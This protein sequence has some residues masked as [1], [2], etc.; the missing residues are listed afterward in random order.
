MK[1][2]QSEKIKDILDDLYEIDP[3][4][5]HYEEEIKKTIKELLKSKPN[6]KI[7][8]KF[9]SELREK[10]I[11]R[12]EELQYEPQKKGFSFW[13]TFFGTKFSYAV[14]GA[15]V[16]VLFIG[17]FVYLAN[18]GNVPGLNRGMFPKMLEKTSLSN[19]A[20][21]SLKSE[22]QNV[23]TLE[24]RGGGGFGGGGGVQV[25]AVAEFDSAKM[26]C[27]GTDCTMPVYYPPKYVYN[28]EAVELKDE[29]VEVLRKKNKLEYTRSFSGLLE[30][31]GFGLADLTG[32]DN[33][34][35]QTIN[36]VQ[37][38]EFGYSI[39]ISLEEGIISIDAY[40]PKWPH[41]QNRCTDER[42]VMENSL[43]LSDIPGDEQL[44]NIAKNFISEH[45]IN[46][47]NYGEPEVD[48]TWNQ[49][50]YAQP[51]ETS[52]IY[53]PDIITVKYPLLI[54]GKF[55]YEQGG[56]KQG[57][58]IGINI[59][60]KKVS[61]VYNLSV[62]EYESSLYEAETDFSKILKVAEKGGLYNYYM[63]GEKVQEIEIGAPEFAYSIIW[64]Y[65]ENAQT[66]RTLLV[67][68]LV[69]PIIK[70]PGNYPSYSDK[71][72]IPLAKELLESVDYPMPMPLMEGTLNAQ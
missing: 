18:F 21:G 32:F 40:W 24:G 13:Q 37:D 48:K 3:V 72:V 35:I 67:P 34:R 39:F 59:R 19:N 64:K 11:K 7:D 31:F 45:R 66:T 60:E 63:P 44:I 50:Y 14:S 57:I 26:I 54:N 61:G 12:V 71:V 30:S 6:I 46:L 22:T 9:V 68:A 65:D 58:G 62:Q 25:S 69:F 53:V 8:Q 29:K 70:D 56:S 5:E 43:S 47:S 41:P 1:N 42:C 28:G 17:I 4:L 2:N 23:A 20:F 16:F 55:V 52:Q 49:M 33:T 15:L 51:V 10:I 27:S 38:K 36:L